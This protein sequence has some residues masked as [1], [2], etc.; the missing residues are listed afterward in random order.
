MVNKWRQ[1]ANKKEMR[2]GFRGKQA[3]L[4][5]FYQTFNSFSFLWSLADIH[6]SFQ[7]SVRYHWKKN[8]SRRKKCLIALFSGE[9]HLIAV[10]W[11]N[12]SVLIQ[13]SACLQIHYVISLLFS[14]EIFV[15]FSISIKEVVGTVA[16]YISRRVSVTASKVT[17]KKR[18]TL[19]VAQDLRM[20]GK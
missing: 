18:K 14:Y 2:F 5:S 13:V 6:A 1:C 7:T 12:I 20:I 19:E 8:F 3:L 16:F 11:E 15:F 10:A 4:V 17:R 9:K